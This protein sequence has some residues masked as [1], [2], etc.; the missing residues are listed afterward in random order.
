V[1]VDPHHAEVGHERGERV[2]GDLRLGGRQHRDQRGLAGR[3]EAD[4]ADVGDALELQ[5]DVEALPRLAELREAG[6]PALGGGQGRVA[7]TAPAAARDLD[8]RTRAHQVGDDLTLGRLHD[9][10]VG[11]L[12]HEVGAL[13]AVAVGAGAAL[14]VLGLDVRPVVEVQKRVRLR[15][16]HQGHAAPVAAVAPVGTAERL[17]LLPVDGDAAVPAVARAQVQDDPVDERG[18]VILASGEVRAE[19][20]NGPGTSRSAARSAKVVTAAPPG[21]C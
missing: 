14:A 21:R 12:D 7:A 9:R 1:V 2:V 15:V 13:G 10:A 4:Q 8:G 17:E 11:H 16:D 6:R 3:R 20:A 19:K 18:H 5:D